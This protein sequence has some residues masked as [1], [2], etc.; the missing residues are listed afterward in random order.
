MKKDLKRAM[1]KTVNTLRNIFVKL[2]DSRGR[3]SPAI[4]DL[5]VQVLKMK[6]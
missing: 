4:S 5:E 6:E 3:K 1:F 2:K